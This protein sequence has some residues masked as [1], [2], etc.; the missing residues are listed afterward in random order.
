MR[1]SALIT[2]KEVYLTLP[3]FT[4]VN[5]TTRECDKN[6]TRKYK[7]ELLT[8]VFK[9]IGQV[10]P[11]PHVNLYESR[12]RVKKAA[13]S[14]IRIL[15]SRQCVWGS[16]SEPH[17]KEK[18]MNTV[19]VREEIGEFRT[20]ILNTLTGI[21]GIVNGAFPGSAKHTIPIVN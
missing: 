11:S 7:A 13:K 3:E 1:P 6:T 19:R 10:D 14:V 16:V 21:G 4:I 15:K 9:M 8:I 12:R 18:T 17:A 2:A 20:Q 5:R